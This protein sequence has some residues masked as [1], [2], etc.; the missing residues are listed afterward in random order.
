MSW[1]HYVMPTL[2]VVGV[3]GGTA[4]LL[5]MAMYGVSPGR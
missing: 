2:I 1:R 4:F 3:L 5:F